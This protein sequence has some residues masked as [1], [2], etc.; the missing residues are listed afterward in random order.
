MLHK[1]AALALAACTLSSAA[2]AQW[3]IQNYDG[4]IGSDYLIGV[5]D[6]E[7]TPDGRYF[8]LRETTAAMRVHVF[9][10]ASGAQ[11][12]VAQA[13]GNWNGVCQDA[14]G[15]TNDRAIVIGSKAVVLDLNPLGIL[16]Q[17]D[18]GLEPRDV[19]VTPDGTLAAV[20]GGDAL[21]VLDLVNGGLVAQAPGLPA[22]YLGNQG[23]DVDS[24]V[25][26]DEY[27]VF[28]SEVASGGSR[29][30]RVTVFDLH[31]G[32]GG[33]PQ[34]VFETDAAS[35][36]LGKPNDIALA[37]D[38]SFAAV[39]SDMQV[40]LYDLSTP[41]VQQKWRQGL[42]GDPGPF[43]ASVM[44][45]IE[46]ANNRIATISRRSNGFVGAQLDVFNR[47]GVRKYQFLDGD[48]HDLALTPDADHVVVRTHLNLTLFDVRVFPSQEFLIPLDSVAFTGSHTSWDAGLDSVV[49]TNECVAAMSRNKQETKCRIFDI[50][51]DTLEKTFGTVVTGKPSD[52]EFTPDGG[53]VLFGFLNASMLVDARTGKVLLDEVGSVYPGSPAWCDGVAVDGVRA[54]AFGVGLV[55]GVGWLTLIDLFEEPTRFC[56]TNPNSTGD[57]GKLLV[58]G[59]PSVASNDLVLWGVDLPAGE[60][61]RFFYGDGSIQVPYGDGF[62]CVGGQVARFGV[63]TVGGGG[64]AEYAV[65]NTNLPPNGGAI[66]PGTT[67][68]FQMVHRDKNPTSTFNFTDA[69]SVTFEG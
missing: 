53:R 47:N 18:V 11:V 44:D 48:P 67:W 9:D 64:V 60:F 2:R 37:P 7:F 5:D 63:V 69:L 31:P 68:N 55:N 50:T 59:T 57:P 38:G 36:Q 65:D 17:D 26:S 61:G 39:R 32:G 16:S 34:V 45:S 1:L 41:Q 62:V 10:A 35:D 49:A 56:D 20:R 66:L 46:V 51:G 3:V 21:Y 6:G 40:A 24:V 58:S 43:G 22:E 29:A 19:A 13:S 33:A 54:A 4:N 30:T 15:V 14:I 42:K 23:Y 52:L 27:A 25:A 8:I 12:F 28:T